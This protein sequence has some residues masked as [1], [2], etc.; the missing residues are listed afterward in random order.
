MKVHFGWLTVAL[1]LVALHLVAP[2]VSGEGEASDEQRQKMLEMMEMER[3]A[4]TPGPQ[5]EAL[6]FFLGTWDV[7]TRMVMPGAPAMEP[8]KGTAEYSWLFEGRWLQ[9]RFHGNMMGQTLETFGLTG[10]DNYK[11]KYVLTW[12]DSISTRMTR[13]EGVVCDP[14]GVSLVFYG[15]G[16]EPMMRLHDKAF[17]V[18]QRREGED[19]FVQEIWDLGIGPGGAIVVEMTFTR[20]T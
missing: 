12:V 11:G 7:S 3:K 1:L 10:F 19:A 5:H 6:A 13:C 2:A 20:R 16:D 18:V 17:K 4:G 9:Q 8:T 15:E 14:T